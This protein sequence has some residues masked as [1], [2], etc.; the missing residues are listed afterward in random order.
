MPRSVAKESAAGYTFGTGG[1]TIQ[2]ESDSSFKFSSLSPGDYTLSVKSVNQGVQ[3]D[4]GFAS[5]RIVDS[6]VNANIEV[7]RAAEVHGTVQGPQGLSVTGKQ[8]TLETFGSGFSLLHEAPALD[9]AGPFAIKTLP[10]GEYTFTV[11]DRTGDESVYIKKAVC[12]GR[13]YAGQEFSLAVGATLDCDVVLANDTGIVHGEVASGENPASSAVVVLV[14]ESSQLRKVPR[15]TLTAKTD[16][17]GQ[18]RIGGIIPGDYL[19]FAVSPSPEQAYYALDFAD[20]HGDVA[21]HVAIDSG[22]TQAVR[23]KLSNPE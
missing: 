1:G 18:Y 21:E 23:L 9:A 19:L 10:P 16:T 3:A 20:R 14:P 13:D 2:L 6:N 15:Y 17:S 7:G 12:S 8:I 5:V 22:A 11:S 4:L